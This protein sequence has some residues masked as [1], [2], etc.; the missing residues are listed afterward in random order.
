MDTKTNESEILQRLLLQPLQ[1]PFYKQLDSI[2][3]DFYKVI[4]YGNEHVIED[5]FTQAIINLVGVQYFI[6]IA[7]INQVYLGLHL[8]KELGQEYMYSVML[9]A[10]TELVA[11]VHKVVRLYQVFQ[12]DNDVENLLNKSNR[13]LKHYVKSD[14]QDENVVP[15]TGFNVMTLVKSLRDRIPEIE[16]KYDDLSTYFHGELTTHQSYRKMTHFQQLA[17]Q[18]LSAISIHDEFVN[19][20]LD[21]LIMDLMF[22]HEIVRPLIDRY[23]KKHIED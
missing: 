18:E 17:G 11:R 13:L 23:E 1:S 21:V 6:G 19:K 8:A 3:N 5:S 9:R 16:E 4:Q 7:P 20:L 12:K 14:T 15:L 22:V 2:G 10:M